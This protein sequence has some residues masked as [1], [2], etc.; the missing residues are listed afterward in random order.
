MRSR[1]YGLYI[2][3]NGEVN[4]SDFIE[5]SNSVTIKPDGRKKLI[6][7]YERRMDSLFFVTSTFSVMPGQDNRSFTQE[8]QT[9]TITAVR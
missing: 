1:F 7:A 8:S 5:R 9:F 6:S 2:N 3:D 4:K